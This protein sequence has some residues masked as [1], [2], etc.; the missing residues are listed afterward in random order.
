MTR[1]NLDKVPEHYTRKQTLAN[2]ERFIT[3]ELKEMEGKILNSEA[4]NWSTSCSSECARRLNSLPQVQE[5]ASALASSTCWRV[6]R[7][8]PASHTLP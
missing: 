2:A 5:I 6:C 4:Q 7:G 3:P 8:G 1:A